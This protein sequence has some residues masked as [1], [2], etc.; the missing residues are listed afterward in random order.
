[1]I[2][3][4]KFN[5]KLFTKHKLNSIM[6][7]KNSDKKKVLSS[8]ALNSFWTQEHSRMPRTLKNNNTPILSN[9][10][11]KG[12]SR[13]SIGGLEKWCEGNWGVREIFIEIQ[14][15]WSVGHK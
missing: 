5:K 9:S 11:R 12:C 1:M 7:N 10:K 15:G 14:E 2:K 6:I 8:M 4:S 3:S 13:C